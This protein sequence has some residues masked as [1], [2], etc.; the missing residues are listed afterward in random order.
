MTIYVQH[1]Y[2]FYLYFCRSWIIMYSESG[3][4][5]ERSRGVQ[6]L[7]CVKPNS[8][9][10]YCWNGHSE[11]IHEHIVLQK[12]IKRWYSFGERVTLN[13]TF[14]TFYTN[15]PFLSMEN[16]RLFS[17]LNSFLFSMVNLDLLFVLLSIPLIPRM[18]CK[19]RQ[20]SIKAFHWQKSIL[21]VSPIAEVC[22]SLFYSHSEQ[23]HFWSFLRTQLTAPDSLSAEWWRAAARGNCLLLWKFS[24]LKEQCPQGR[25]TFLNG[26][27]FLFRCFHYRWK[28]PMKILVM[29]NPWLCF[30]NS[31][32]A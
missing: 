3:M 20:G 19:V 4:L 24:D 32:W 5:L 31:T 12:C 29:K 10:I 14:N 18:V 21:G 8:V 30:H 11:M 2:S 17:V 26:K 23:M 1:F 6:S 15:C 7:F 25:T 13:D 28:H 22:F 9:A 27:A 16:A